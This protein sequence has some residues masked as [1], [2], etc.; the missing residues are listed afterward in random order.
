MKICKE[1]CV[2]CNEC[3]IRLQKSNT[4]CQAHNS[5]ILQDM[6]V[7]RGVLDKVK[8]E[9]GQ[10]R[11][12]KRIDPADLDITYDEPYAKDYFAEVFDASWERKPGKFVVKIRKAID[13][14][15]CNGEMMKRFILEAN[16]A[17]GMNDDNIVRIMGLTLLSDD[18]LGI[19]MKKANNGSLE[20]C[21]T[22][23]NN[24]LAVK[25]SN[26]I[27]DGLEYLHE[28]RIAHLGL[29]PSNVLLFG[30]DKIPKLTD[31]GNPKVIEKLFLRSK[32]RKY[33]APEL[34]TSTYRGDA[35]DIYSFSVM[36]FEMF[37]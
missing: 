21:L 18:R 26:G 28:K 37:S 5:P 3:L 22:K 24:S 32:D 31:F 35:V 4:P 12:A 19:V 34:I 36:L 10:L 1:G 14:L 11:N 13:K 25:I 2:R 33:S 15:S 6:T 20:D 16:L 27:L 30:S 8:S 17:S 7:E 23:L 9:L 29:K